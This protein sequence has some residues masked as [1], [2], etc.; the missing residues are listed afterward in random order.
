MNV[1]DQKITARLIRYGFIS[2]QH[3]DVRMMKSIQWF[4]DEKLV[5]VETSPSQN[6]NFYIVIKRG[7][8]A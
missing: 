5:K 8:R 1:S 7:S 6:I 3:S 4:I 2:I